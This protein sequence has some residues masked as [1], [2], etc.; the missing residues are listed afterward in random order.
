MLRWSGGLALVASALLVFILVKG[1]LTLEVTGTIVAPPG[2]GE[3][4]TSTPDRR[5]I[6]LKSDQPGW[7]LD[8][9]MDKLMR[10]GFS[11][12]GSGDGVDLPTTVW[13]WVVEVPGEVAAAS[14]PGDRAVFRS[15]TLTFPGF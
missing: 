2:A 10:S 9:F 7:P 3:S 13:T 15:Q 4:L 5:Q 1:T 6:H 11:M 8:E 12:T 14:T